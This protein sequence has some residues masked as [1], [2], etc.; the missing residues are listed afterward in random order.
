MADR[1]RDF[2]AGFTAA[3]ELHNR[4]GRLGAFIESVC[5]AAT[6]VDGAL[7]I[8]LILRHQ[9]NTNT[10]EV[11]DE[12]LFQGTEDK[13]VL[14]RVVYKRALEQKVIDAQL[15]EKL[16][17]LYQQR[18]RVVHRYII[19]E[20]TTEDVLNIGIAYEKVIQDVSA[21]VGILEQ[22]Q[23]KMGV[24]MT[25]SEK[26]EFGLGEF[27]DLSSGKHGNA[28]LTSGLRKKNV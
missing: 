2:I 4:A 15:F 28:N 13:A 1:L 14:E 5:L 19:S 24:G 18:N 8:G 12:L 6:I 10:A 26:V 9:L 21:A 27:L 7:R 3:V 25:R 16:E 22:E 11:L 23:I 17:S 20:L